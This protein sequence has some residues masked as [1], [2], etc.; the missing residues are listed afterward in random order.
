[1]FVRTDSRGQQYESHSA[2]PVTKNEHEEP[3]ARLSRLAAKKLDSAKSAELDSDA[4]HDKN[5]H[6]SNENMRL[7]NLWDGIETMVA[8]MQME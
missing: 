4:N 7:Q 1:M 6:S 8:L 3:E 2:S 5:Q